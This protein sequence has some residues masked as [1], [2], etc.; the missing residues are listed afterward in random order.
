[1]KNFVVYIDDTGTKD[2]EDSNT[3]F[4]SYCGIIIE[5]KNVRSSIDKIKH[6]KENLLDKS[7]ELKSRWFRFPHIRKEKYLNPFNLTNADF[8]EFSTKLFSLICSLPIHC[9]GAVLD[10][11]RHISQYADPYNP[12]AMCYELLLQHIANYLTQ[13][14]GY[15][16][17]IIIDDMT[18]K[19]KKGNDWKQLLINQHK[20]MKKGKSPLYRTWKTREKMDYSKIPDEIIFKNSE[21]STMIQVADLCAYNV[22]RQGLRNWNNFDHKPYY[23]GYEWIKK[24]MH[25]CPSTGKITRFGAIC[26][27]K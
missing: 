7:I 6:L 14:D 9:L 4:F 24:I 5:R 22:M 19:T 1:M 27:P 26:F 25:R 8:T 17:K 11:E 12:S 21:V 18:G 16:S 13:Y 3:N 2:L 15:L 23:I 10:K 20:E